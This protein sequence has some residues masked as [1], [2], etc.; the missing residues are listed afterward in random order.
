MTSSSRSQLQTFVVVSMV[1]WEDSPACTGARRLME[2]ARDGGLSRS[3]VLVPGRRAGRLLHRELLRDGPAFLEPP[4]ILTPTGLVES[5]M[6]PVDDLLPA[7][8][9]F[10][11]LVETRGTSMSE[12]FLFLLFAVRALTFL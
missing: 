8:D 6:A 11:E 4:T 5:F 9:I 10:A 3:A 1:G 7:T 12:P 2:L